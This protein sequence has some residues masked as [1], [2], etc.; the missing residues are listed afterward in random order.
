MLIYEE[1]IPANYRAAFVEKIKE[2][3]SRLGINPNWL[4]AVIN[5]ESAGSFSSSIKNP[6]TGATGLIQF[7]PS[8]AI[9]LGTTVLQLSQMSAVEQLDY[10]Y[11][12]YSTYKNKL[13]GYVDLYLT[14]FFPVAVGKPDNYVLS[15]KNISESVIAKQNPAFDINKDGK[16]TVGEIKQVML[17]KIPSNWL[18]QFDKKKIAIGLG[19][20]VVITGTIYLIKKLI[21]A[22]KKND[23]RNFK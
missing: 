7:M 12:Y 21:K 14:T 11:K 6:Y 19:S 15:T 2:V 4:M 5:F 13:N 16:I 9:G 23:T 20:L 18:N 17:S 8:T 10:V 3:S 1:K 22:K